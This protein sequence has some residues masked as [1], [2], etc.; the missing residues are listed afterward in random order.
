[1][2]ST[3]FCVYHEFPLTVALFLCAA[4]TPTQFKCRNGECIESSGHCNGVPDCHDGSDELSCPRC[5]QDEFECD[6]GMCISRSARC[7]GRSDCSD[8]SD[9]YNCN[10]TTCSGDQ[11]RC[12]DGTCLN[13]NKRCN[14]VADCRNGED[15]KQCGCGE[16]EFR[17]TDGRCIGYELQCNGVNECSDGSDER[18]CEKFSRRNFYNAKRFRSKPGKASNSKSARS[19]S[20]VGRKI[21]E[22][23]SGR[24]EILPFD[25]SSRRDQDRKSPNSKTAKNKKRVFSPVKQK[26]AKRIFDDGKS[27][28]IKSKGHNEWIPGGAKLANPIDDAYPELTNEVADSELLSTHLMKAMMNRM[29]GSNNDTVTNTRAPRFKNETSKWKYD[30]QLEE[31]IFKRFLVGE[32]INRNYSPLA[33]KISDKSENMNGTGG[34]AENDE[35]RRSNFKK[36][37]EDERRAKCENTRQEE[38]RMNVKNSEATTMF[39]CD[40][41]DGNKSSKLITNLIEDKPRSST[42]EMNLPPGNKDRTTANAEV[43]NEEGN[44]TSR[45]NSL[46]IMSKPRYRKYCN[47]Y[48]KHLTPSA[49]FFTT[50]APKLSDLDPTSK[51]KSQR[52]S[53]K[54]DALFKK[55]AHH[56]KS[57]KNSYPDRKPMMQYL[58]STD[59]NETSFST[60]KEFTPATTLEDF[61]YRSTN[62]GIDTITT[63]SPLRSVT[64]L[65]YQTDTYTKIKVESSLFD[66][67]PADVKF[68]GNFLSKDRILQVVDSEAGDVTRNH[69]PATS[70]KFEDGEKSDSL[71]I[72]EEFTNAYEE[73]VDSSSLEQ[74]V[75]LSSNGSDRNSTRNLSSEE[76]NETPLSTW[77]QDSL[78]TKEYPTSESS[79][80]EGTVALESSTFIIHSPDTSTKFAKNDGRKEGKNSRKM[81]RR[82]N[83]NER[84]NRKNRHPTQSSSLPS[85]PDEN[86]E[87]PVESLNT[88]RNDKVEDEDKHALNDDSVIEN[89]SDNSPEFETVTK[90]IRS[91]ESSTLED[92]RFTKT[93]TEVD[94]LLNT[95]QDEE[96]LEEIT[97]KET[98]STSLRSTESL[99]TKKPS[100]CKKRSTTTA[101]YSV[102]DSWFKVE[103]SSTNSEE[104]CEETVASSHDSDTESTSRTLDPT[105]I[106]EKVSSSTAKIRDESISK[107]VEV[108][109]KASRTTK[110]RLIDYEEDSK[111]SHERSST[112][113]TETRTL[114][115]TSRI[116][117]RL[118]ESSS[119]TSKA[120]TPDCHCGTSTHDHG[121]ASSLSARK[122]EE[123]PEKPAFSM[124]SD[125]EFEEYSEETLI[126]PDKQR[127]E[128]NQREDSVSKKR[129]NETEDYSNEHCNEEQYACDEYTCIEESQICDGR[130]DCPDVSDEINCDYYYEKI[131]EAR[132]RTMKD[133]A[134][135]H[136]R[137]AKCGRYEYPC[138]GRCISTALV[139]DEVRDC[140]DGADEEDCGDKDE[141]RLSGSSD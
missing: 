140:E 30:N 135:S 73:N 4:C 40:M 57:T 68:D 15:E 101:T 87:T 103:P 95:S 112:I 136:W 96:T 32:S 102:W 10:V 118:Y 41:R 107:E 2:Q 91:V 51:R 129:S 138:D 7:N 24:R 58:K 49:T 79:I 64:R 74:E 77:K 69:S 42:I 9:E 50:V 48:L 61:T 94:K 126:E 60:L 134:R 63:N 46:W 99:S 85:T 116:Q 17:C 131:M 78:R 80:L 29:N 130:V 81:K 8:Y 27:K 97:L 31:D 105:E 47:E 84:K 53:E 12:L 124:S 76:S 43:S 55:N 11:F 139:C 127:K 34:S 100:K 71:G 21:E 62:S 36:L 44:S 65:R 121:N 75:T 117:E 33:G 35:E 98:K 113:T 26:R 37:R 56:D 89:K 13:I 108:T 59:Q 14:G 132:L 110:D 38:G 109:R 92:E 128:S 5:R 67:S 106:S 82:R 1:M 114:S 83:K 72:L 90:D 66:S 122:E 3:W 25:S 123:R 18:D 28:M 137:G 119:T 6:D 54:K 111:D 86:G 104:D 23:Q 70:G 115:T 20:S 22:N 120:K 125:N 88:S 133:R 45:C 52:D 93:V 39:P 141:G 19:G 16:A